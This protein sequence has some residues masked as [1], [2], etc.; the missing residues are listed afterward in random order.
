MSNVNPDVMLNLD[1][2]ADAAVL[3]R[4]A[5]TLSTSQGVLTVYRS[6]RAPRLVLVQYDARRTS[7][8][9]ILHQARGEGVGAN[10]VGM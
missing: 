4:V 7:S 10:L 2:N 5:S 3:E 9:S 1:R 6:P 8:Q